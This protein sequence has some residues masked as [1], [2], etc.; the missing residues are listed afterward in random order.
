MV[1]GH[2]GAAS[3]DCP[4][5]T[6]AAVDRALRQGADGVEVDVR[7][8]ADA[9]PVVHHDPGLRRTAGVPG[10]VADLKADE[11]PLLPGGHAVPRMAEVLDLVRGRGRLVLELKTPTWPAGAA[12][13]F[14]HSVAAELRRHRLDDVVV[15]SFDRTRL[16][17]VRELGLC[18]TGL[19]T[20]PGIPLAVGLRRALLDAHAELHPHVT[21][22]LPCRH[23]V[24]EA[25]V[26]VTPWTVDRPSDLR[27]LREAGVAGV[28]CDDPAAARR[29]LRHLA[30]VS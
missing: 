12:T 4:E 14:V 15:S 20:R 24:A 19:L 1:L 8:T 28:I 30:A 11:L 2:R 6:L 10:E 23:L 18:P 16:L 26:A 17:Q 25:G 21:S 7:L 29:S 5:N 9:V 3:S 27:L 13:L 22:V